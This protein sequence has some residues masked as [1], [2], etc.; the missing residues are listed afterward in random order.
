MPGQGP[1][2]VLN[3]DALSRGAPV[4]AY[5]GALGSYAASLPI[6][7]PTGETVALIQALLKADVVLAPVSRSTQRMLIVALVIAALATGSAVFVGRYWISAVAGLTEAAAAPRLGRLLD[8]DPG[9]RRHG[10]RR[11]SRSTHG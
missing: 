8:V 7:A 9:R 1:F 4:A 10:G 2:A 11:C 6:A 5:I 3:T